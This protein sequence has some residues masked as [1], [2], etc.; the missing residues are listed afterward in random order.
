M[1]LG[2]AAEGVALA[3]LA[4]LFTGSL[5]CSLVGALLAALGWITRVRGF[6]IACL[7]LLLMNQGFFLIGGAWQA[8][9]SLHH[10][11]ALYMSITSLVAVSAAIGLR[12]CK[13]RT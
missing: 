6:L 12:R 9:F 11:P 7:L 5:L 13:A 3:G 2:T 8:V 4:T 10:F 1:D